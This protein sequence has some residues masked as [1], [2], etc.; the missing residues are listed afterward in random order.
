MKN[1]PPV[2]IVSKVVNIPLNQGTDR[3]Y[4]L[5]KKELLQNSLVSGVTA[6]QDVLGSHLDQS[7]IEFKGDGPMRELTSTRLIVDAGLSQPL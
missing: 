2:L 7:G 1:G 3:K 5:L 4:D 6:S